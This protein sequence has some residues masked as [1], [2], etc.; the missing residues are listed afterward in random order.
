MLTNMFRR[1]DYWRKKA[2]YRKHMKAFLGKM[3]INRI[4]SFAMLCILLFAGCGKKE[5]PHK[6]LN[7][8][9]YYV[10]DYWDSYDLSKSVFPSREDFESAST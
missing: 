3:K 8:E 6:E 4:L 1:D 5:I 7:L 10:A 9:F 2:Q